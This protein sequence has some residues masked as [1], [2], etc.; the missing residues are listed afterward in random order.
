MQVEMNDIE[1][2][3]SVTFGMPGVRSRRD[4]LVNATQVP[5]RAISTL[6]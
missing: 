1:P 6:I 4:M 2:G 5:G 3:T